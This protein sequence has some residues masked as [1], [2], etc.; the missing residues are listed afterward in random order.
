[1]ISFC[2]CFFIISSDFSSENSDSPSNWSFDRGRNICSLGDFCPSLVLSSKG[3]PLYDAGVFFNIFMLLYF[4]SGIGRS[5]G[6]L[7][8]VVCAL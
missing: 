8:S 3:L 4:S 6:N 1:M 2:L 5:K 7:S